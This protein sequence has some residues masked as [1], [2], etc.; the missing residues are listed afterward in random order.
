VAGP[1]ATKLILLNGPPGSG[2]STLARRYVADHPLTLHLEIDAVRVALGGWQDHGESKLLA[3]AIA[4]AMAETQLRFGYD[5]IVPQY[6]GRTEFIEALDHLAASLQVDF[7]E[8][9]LLDDEAAIID[10]FLARRLE[11]GEPH[12]E[13]D[14]ADTA[15]AATIATAL[16]QLDAVA[17]ARPRT[18]VV[19]MSS[20]LEASYE[21]LRRAVG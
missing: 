20:D 11:P 16:D 6:L 8:I 15:V 19:K 5:V 4:L 14:V 18:R 1:R 7:V 9:L 21:A 17:T 3:R 13:A 10:R 2:K 12:P